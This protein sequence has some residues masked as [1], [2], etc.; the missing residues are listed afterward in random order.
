MIVDTARQVR[1]WHPHTPP[2]LDP[3]TLL[4]ILNTPFFYSHLSAPP[5]SSGTNTP[6]AAGWATPMPLSTRTSMYSM[7]GG[8]GSASSPS[9]HQ[10]MPF[11]AQSPHKRP[12]SAGSIAPGAPPSSWSSR[13]A[14]SRTNSAA[15]L[16]APPGQDPHY[17]MVLP[18]L[19]YILAQLGIQPQ[20]QPGSDIPGVSWLLSPQASIV[21]LRPRIGTPDEHADRAHAKR[22]TWLAIV[23][24]RRGKGAPHWPAISS[25]GAPTGGVPP[26]PP[27]PGWVPR[28]PK[29]GGASGGSSSSSAGESVS[30]TTTTTFSPLM[31]P[32]TS[33][34]SHSQFGVESNGLI[35]P[36]WMREWI[37]EVEGTVEGRRSLENILRGQFVQ[38]P[39]ANGKPQFADSGEREWEV[40]RE[41]CGVG[42]VWMRSVSSM[43]DVV[44]VC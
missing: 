23:D 14:P 38:A 28:R 37:L 33:V 42:R 20:I 40:I 43:A 9:L 32:S 5:P 7:S 3:S 24:L 13:P 2:P 27:L 25:T 39:S 18:P 41:K 16:G 21:P 29:M 31:T 30:T 11:F 26:V 4:N 36:G 10:P 17:R 22:W 15:R 8:W 6:T 34:S 35:A 19:G 44:F 12:G 1:V